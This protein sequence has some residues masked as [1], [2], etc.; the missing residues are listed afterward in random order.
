MYQVFEWSPLI[1]ISG[2]SEFRVLSAQFGDGYAQEAG[3]GI[4]NKQS[5]YSLRFK[6][7]YIEIADIIYFLDQHQGYIPFYFTPK[8]R[9][10]EALL[11][12]CKGYSKTNISDNGQN[13]GIWSLSCTFNQRFEP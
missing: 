6:G 10:D 11:F 7:K 3:D 4:N 5:S 1:E 13:N 12:T 2:S 9:P 8:D